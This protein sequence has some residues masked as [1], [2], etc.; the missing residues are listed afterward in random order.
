[1]EPVIVSLDDL[2]SK[3]KEQLKDYGSSDDPG[4]SER[5]IDGEQESIGNDDR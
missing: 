5:I 3:S 1:M 2:L 4:R